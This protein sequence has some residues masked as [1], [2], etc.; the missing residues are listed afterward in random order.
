MNRSLLLLLTFLPAAI[1]AHPGHDL[2]QHGGSH[3]A[4]SPYHLAFLGLIALAS[5]GIAVLVRNWRLKLFFRGT[6]LLSLLSVAVLWA[7]R[8]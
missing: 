4:M 1:Y 2:M 6:G 3:V 7:L 8:Y 5:L